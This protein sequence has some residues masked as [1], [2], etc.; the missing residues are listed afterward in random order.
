ML[1]TIW[2]VSYNCIYI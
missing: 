2:L 1:N